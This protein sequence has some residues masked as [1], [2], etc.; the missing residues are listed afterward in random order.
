MTTA[1][2]PW[3]QTKAHLTLHERKKPMS[4]DASDYDLRQQ[5]AAARQTVSDAIAPLLALEDYTTTHGFL[6]EEAARLA[7][8][9]T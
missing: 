8:V 6:V 9:V 3:R 2:A 7:G 5:I 4:D 1:S